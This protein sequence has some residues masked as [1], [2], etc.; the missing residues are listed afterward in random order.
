MNTAKKIILVPID[1]S[2][3]SIVAL[4]Q[5]KVIAKVMNGELF[6]LHVTE[7]QG[8]ISTIFSGKQR[9]SRL[10]FWLRRI[11]YF[12]KYLCLLSFVPRYLQQ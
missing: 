2:E 8:F 4:N 1:F 10:I 5:A 3:Q 7:E 12:G 9:C 6:L 11:C